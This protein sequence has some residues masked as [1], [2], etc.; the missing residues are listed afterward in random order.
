MTCKRRST[1]RHTG[2]HYMDYCTGIEIVSLEILIRVSYCPLRLCKQSLFLEG[3]NGNGLTS[4]LNNF[5]NLSQ[6]EWKTERQR[7]RATLKKES[8]REKERES[9]YY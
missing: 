9:W 8:R 6:T 3:R 7:G 5:N 2:D 4:F 1:G